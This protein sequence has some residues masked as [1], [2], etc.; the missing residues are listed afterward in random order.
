MLFGDAGQRIFQAEFDLPTLGF[1][2]H[3]RIHRLSVVYRTTEEIR[4]FA[5]EILPVQ[6]DDLAGG[7]FDHGAAMS[8]LTGPGP[9]LSRSST[10][11]EQAEFVASQIRT[12]ASSSLRYQD[13]A[14]FSR[15]KAALDLVRQA[16]QR[17]SIPI[18]RVGDDNRSESDGV[19]LG[20]M[21]AAKGL[22]FKVVFIVDASKGKLPNVKGLSEYADDID[23]ERYLE[24]ERNLLYVSVT[25]ARDQVFI[26]YVKEPSVF[27]DPL[28]PVNGRRP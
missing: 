27:L 18:G 8:L 13:F 16:L 1:D 21:H 28:L 9:V 15:T 11:A 4:K 17:H 14:V 10:R 26:C 7:Q 3:G 22:E 6:V 5:E 25:R 2:V 24:S 19:R 23:K 20:T 12:L